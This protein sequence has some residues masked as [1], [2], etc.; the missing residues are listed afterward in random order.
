MLEKLKL[1]DSQFHWLVQRLLS[2]GTK[3]IHKSIAALISNRFSAVNENIIPK[4]LR[5]FLEDGGEI[6]YITTNTQY[7]R[8]RKLEQEREKLRGIIATKLG[9]YSNDFIDVLS[10]DES[11]ATQEYI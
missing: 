2:R 7:W 3:Q 5:R 4:E 10:K 9:Y 6:A 8:I 11:P 1:S